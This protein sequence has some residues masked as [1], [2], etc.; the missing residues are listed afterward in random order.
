M[1]ELWK[2][3][4]EVLGQRR[5]EPSCTP[6]EKSSTI[7]PA[8]SNFKKRNWIRS[9]KIKTAEA[10]RY[11]LIRHEALERFLMDGRIEIDS[12]IVERA[13]RPHTITT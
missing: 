1:A 3:E 13:I 10:I 6:P 8:S 11:P 2:I 5:R 9:R 4:V 12:Q 7:V